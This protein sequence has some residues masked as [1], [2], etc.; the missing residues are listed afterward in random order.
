MGDGGKEEW[1]LRDIDLTTCQ[2]CM[3]EAFFKQVLSRVAGPWTSE[4][5]CWDIPPSLRTGGDH[6][7]PIGDACQMYLG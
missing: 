3:A 6:P 7:W 1:T 4:Y 2:R 5:N